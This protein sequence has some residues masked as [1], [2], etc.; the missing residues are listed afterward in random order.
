MNSR[1]KI[2]SFVIM[3]AIA[4]LVGSCKKDSVLNPLN[5]GDCTKLAENINTALEAYINNPSVA[6][7]ESYKSALQDYANGCAGFAG[8]NAAWA[9]AIDDLD[10]S[11]E[12]N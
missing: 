10:C 4:M 1:T 6:T 7:C 2:F 11:E 3:F 8:Y 12:G 5:A 9:A